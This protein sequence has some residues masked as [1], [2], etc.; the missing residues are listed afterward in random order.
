[1][2][3]GTLTSDFVRSSINNVSNMFRLTRQVI[4]PPAA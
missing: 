2:I 4:Q 1:M 3:G